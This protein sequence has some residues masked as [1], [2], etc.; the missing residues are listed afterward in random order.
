[1]CNIWIDILIKITQKTHTEDRT[2]GKLRA[3]PDSHLCFLRRMSWE[4]EGARC[5]F[6]I[7]IAGCYSIL[8]KT[9]FLFQTTINPLVSGSPVQFLI[10]SLYLSKCPD[11][12]L[13]RV[14]LF[15]ELASYF[16]VIKH[17]WGMSVVHLSQIQG[18]FIGISYFL[19]TLNYFIL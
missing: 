5:N 19:S 8:Q 4:S 2:G 6:C 17:G 18:G 12:Q 3:G 10:I 9:L 11:A 1:M 13:L 7:P 14:C 15:F 16:D